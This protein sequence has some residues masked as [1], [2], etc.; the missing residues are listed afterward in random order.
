[1]RNI[2]IS[3]PFHLAASHL[4]YDEPDAHS[5]I[6]GFCAHFSRNIRVRHRIHTGSTME[7]TYMLKT[8]GIDLSGYLTLE[9]NML[10]R[11]FAKYR[12]H[13]QELEDQ[14]WHTEA[15][16]GD[17]ESLTALY[18]NPQDIIMG[19]SKK[20]SASW[21]GN[22]LFNRLIKSQAY[23]YLRES[24]RCVKS[25][26]T[27]ETVHILQT[28]YRARFLA[29]KDS[30]WEVVEDFEVRSKVSQALR[31]EARVLYLKQSKRK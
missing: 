1:M 28:E 24:E 15:P 26:I 14:L 18:P 2:Y 7:M 3:L 5:F 30:C 17:P 16:Y 4:L 10:D 22:I 13:H 31:D 20:V 23:L 12:Q 8:F 6:Q 11:G 9:T 27:I 19:K 25:A 29:R 21:P